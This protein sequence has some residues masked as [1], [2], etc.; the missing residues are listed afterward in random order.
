VTDGQENPN[1]LTFKGN[2]SPWDIFAKER[3]VGG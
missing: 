2:L 1:E 3:Q